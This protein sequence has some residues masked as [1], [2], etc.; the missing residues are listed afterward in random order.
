M[1]RLQPMPLEGCPHSELG[2]TLEHPVNT[3][4]VVPDK[5]LTMKWEP[6]TGKHAAAD[7]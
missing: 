5:L 3:L 2:A 1:S 7:R 4:G 6:A